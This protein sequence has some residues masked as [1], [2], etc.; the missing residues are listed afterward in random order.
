L[1]CDREKLR[2]S[3]PIEEFLRLIVEADST[4]S[5]L[6]MM[7]EAAKTRVGGVEAYARVLLDWYTHD[8]FW[9]H[10]P[11]DN[12]SVELLML[13]ALKVVADPDLRGRIEE[14]LTAKQRSIYEKE[15]GKA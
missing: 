11:E 10:G 1:L 9:I 7:R 2:P 13:D 14:A 4:M 6:R 12:V 8:K 15:A 3:Q 5:L